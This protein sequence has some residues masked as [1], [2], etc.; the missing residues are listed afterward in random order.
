MMVAQVFLMNMRGDFCPYVFEGDFTQEQKDEILDISQL[1]NVATGG[2]NGWF[3]TK[4]GEWYTFSRETWDMGA[5]S[6]AWDDVI[7][8]LKDYYKGD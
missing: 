7:S 8:E 5:S 2:F 3:F 4:S 6:G 1:P